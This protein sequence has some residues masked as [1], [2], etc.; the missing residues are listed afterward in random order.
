MK[1]SKYNLFFK[2]SD[3]SLAFNSM[4]CALAQVDEE[5]YR[6]YNDIENVDAKSLSEKDNKLIKDMLKGGYIIADDC[7]ELKS[8]K[9]R[10]SVGKYNKDFLSLVI[11]PTLEC[12]FACP[13]CYE[14]PKQGIMSKEVQDKL[15][16][17]IKKNAERKR[18]IDI[19]WYGGEPLLA[20]SVIYS[21]SERF[22]KICEENNVEYFASIITNGYLLEESDI[23]KFSKYKITD[24]QITIDGTREIHNSRRILRNT[25]QLGT[26]DQIINNVKNLYNANFEVSIRVNIDKNNIADTKNLIL[27]FKEIGLLGLNINFGHVSAYTEF[28]G[29]IESECLS[30]A[31]Y[32]K[33]SLILQEFLHNNGF[34]A[35]GF[36]YYPGIKGNYCGADSINTY[37]IDAEGYKYKCW[38]EVGNIKQSVGNI[39]LDVN[40]YQDDW[41]AREINYMTWS[42][43]E[44]DKYLEC[45]ILPICMGGC[46]YNGVVKGNKK[47]ERW[48]FGLKESLV[49]MYLQNVQS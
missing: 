3:I 34:E 19:T 26:F 24:I 47:C 35:S 36:P 12:N 33:E 23:E 10:N 32:A 11:A 5:F 21:L 16:E 20:K 13:Y 6:I 40:E 39:M 2:E 37:V 48:K 25:P 31:Q 46:P 29:E 44:N 28:N 27:Y 49:K 38:N 17:I 41:I 9:F 4:T 14:N 22:I 45:N 15:V 43:F 7:D 30:M 1:K 18:R 42:P 8:I